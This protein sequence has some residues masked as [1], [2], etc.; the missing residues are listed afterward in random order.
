MLIFAV[1]YILD[2]QVTSPPIERTPKYLNLHIR[3]LRPI[4]GTVPPPKTPQPTLCAMC[5][6]KLRKKI[7]FY[8]RETPKKPPQPRPSWG[9]KIHFCRF[10]PYGC[11]ERGHHGAL[12]ACKRG[13]TTWETCGATCMV[14]VRPTPPPVAVPSTQNGQNVVGFWACGGLAGARRGS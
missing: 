2:S 14:L 12:R 8:D 11:H 10:C 7:E 6:E 5:P 3:P 13:T 4:C 9:K 1:Q